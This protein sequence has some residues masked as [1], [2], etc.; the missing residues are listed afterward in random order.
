VTVDDWC[1]DADG[2]FHPGDAAVLVAAY[3]R[4]RPLTAAECAAWPT[5]LRRAALRFWLSRLHDMHFPRSGVLIK[6]KS[7]DRF[8]RILEGHR[9]NDAALRALL[10]AAS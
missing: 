7:P 3:S 8:R 1:S 4:R 5:L 6:K 10:D 9:G 2:T